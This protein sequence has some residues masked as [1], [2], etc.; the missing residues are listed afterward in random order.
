[1]GLG[2]HGLGGYGLVEGERQSRS[3]EPGQL[4]DQGLTVRGQAA[5][6]SASM[7]QVH[8]SQ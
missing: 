6:T 4:S 7:V 3:G 5:S 1:M 8:P 2:G